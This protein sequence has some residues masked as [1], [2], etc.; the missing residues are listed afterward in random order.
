MS[1]GQCEPA[2]I[3]MAPEEPLFAD[4]A[5][6]MK[7]VGHNLWFSLFYD[8]PDQSGQIARVIMRHV[9]MSI[10]G[11]SSG[12]LEVFRLLPPREQ[13]KVRKIAGCH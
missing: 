6:N 8:R 2:T 3:D 1:S 7:I 13:V 9:V 4:G 12:A 11:A 10:D 5:T